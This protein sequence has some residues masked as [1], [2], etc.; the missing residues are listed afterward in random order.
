MKEI[1]KRELLDIVGEDRFFDDD[2]DR[3]TYSYDGSFLPLVPPHLPEAVVQPRSAEEVAAVLR[4]CHAHGVP[5]VP[6]GAG[7]GR[8]GGSVPVAGGVVL[9]LQRMNRILDLD[10]G[11]MMALVEPGVVTFDFCQAMERKGFFYPPD[12]A[13]WKFCTLG[14]NV[15]ENAGGA[16][17]VKYGVTRDYVMGLQVV[18]ADGRVIETGGKA[19]K[20]VTGYD[21]TRL[22]VGSEGTLGVITRILLRLLPLPP[23]KKTLLLCFGSVD[24]ASTAVVRMIQAGVIPAAA[25]LMDRVSIDAVA[26][27][28]P[29][30]VPAGTEAAVLVDIDGEPEVLVPQARR[31]VAVAREAGAI[32]IREA[33]DDAEADA[34]WLLRR[35]MGPA[36]AAMAPNKIGEDIAVPR[37]VVPE[38]I[39][40]LQDIGRRYGF[41][42]AIFGHAGDGNLHPSILTDLSQEGNQE[43]ADAAVAEVFRA[44]LELGG[45]LSGEHGIGITKLPFI[46]DALG[47]AQVDVLKSIKRALDP[48]GILN[49]GKIFSGGA[50][51]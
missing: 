35:A 27:A 13:S 49:P 2:L 42:I 36:V 17:A 16:R 15:A 11:N 37:T 18:L 39:R 31:V 24:A 38:M 41:T 8:T 33:A 28:H 50:E 7:S 6:R 3:F 40:R 23:A 10:E 44:A 1:V 30:H 51:R 21:L 34:L 4:V 22:F 47:E 12:P 25:E 14:G 29:V 43:K 45:T 32:E 20:N 9:S 48:K 19:V 46:T 26:R 5:V